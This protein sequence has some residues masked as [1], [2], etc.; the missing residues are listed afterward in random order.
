MSKIQYELVID[1]HKSLSTLSEL[2]KHVASL[3]EE[4]KGVD[5]GSDA[6]RKLQREVQAA[7]AQ[8]KNATKSIEGMDF[9]QIAGEAGKFAGGVGA[10]TASFV[11][12]GGEGNKTM[13]QLQKQMNK[14]LGIV[15]GV[16]GAIEAFTSAAKLARP[17]MAALNKVIQA[18]PIGIIVAGVLAL[19][20]AIYAL[21]RNTKELNEETEDTTK[22]MESA[23]SKISS[24]LSELSKYQRQLE[25]SKGSQSD[26]NEAVKDWNENI[27]VNYNESLL[28]TS[29]SL[30]DI[31]RAANAATL[32]IIKMG[33]AS[34]Y[35]DQI[36]KLY[37]ENTEAIKLYIESLE[38]STDVEEIRQKT[39]D[40]YWDRPYAE[41]QD[42][43]N[44]R[45]KEAGLTT[46]T[47]TEEEIALQH[48]GGEVYMQIQDILTVIDEFNVTLD[49]NVKV[50][51]KDTKA[52]DKQTDALEKY[53][54]WMENWLKL[55]SNKEAT[56][57]WANYLYYTT[58]YLDAQEEIIKNMEVESINRVLLNSTYEEGIKIMNKYYEEGIINEEQYNSYLL[59]NIDKVQEANEK[60]YEWGLITAEE[61]NMN[62]KQIAENNKTTWL[63]KILGTDEDSANEIFDAA[64]DIANTF[65]NMM[66]EIT[67]NR[68]ERENE[69]RTN[70]LNA[71]MERELEMVGDNAAAQEA[72]RERYAAKQG[73]MEEEMAKREKQIAIAE[74]TINGALAIVKTWAGYAALGPAGAISASI[75][76]ALIAATTAAQIAVIQSQKFAKGG[77][78]NGP[79][80]AQ[81]G[82]LTNFG[83]L[84]GGEA[85]I[86]KKSTSQYAPI[87]SAINQANG[88]NPIGNNMGNLIDYDLLAIKI[89]NVINDKKV[90]VNSY[91]I[92]NQ[93][94]IDVKIENRAS[95]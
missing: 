1:D 25:N 5:R 29:S 59:D 70:A 7:D 54:V 92:T 42:E 89:G 32:S 20:T 71:Q 15:M 45:L 8:L 66:F 95:I 78:L 3:K 83:E 55:T 46:K 47:L 65:S 72:I 39:L 63:A 24:N 76:S 27:G 88:G 14:A 53:G 62:L 68:L 64:F 37:A 16:K 82:I 22:I 77:I 17:V 49:E 84:E 34:A 51:N 30:D 94:G 79:S 52:I 36:T 19:G 93:Q 87:L 57:E 18:N 43:Y 91:D 85:V 4:I 11:L 13:E 38:Y 23:G 10:I 61:Y 6:F 60:A 9:D 74:A 81:G 35:Q 12:L 28:T 73:K 75:Q 86:N 31:Q 40:E 80:H 33:I 50:V 67:S 41:F 69:L 44:K 58:Q 2:E 26:F 21:T 48:Q 90:Y 56:D